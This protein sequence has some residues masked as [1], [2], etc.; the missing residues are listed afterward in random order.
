MLPDAA[1]IF[2]S[3]TQRIK[4]LAGLI[5]LS[6]VSMLALQAYFLQAD[7]KTKKADFKA[8]LDAML[9]ITAQEINMLRKEEINRMHRLD[10]LDTSYVKLEYD[11]EDPEGPS[12]NVFKVESQSHELTYRVGWDKVSKDSVSQQYLFDRFFNPIHRDS[13]S[14]LWAITTSLSD[15]LSAYQ[16]TLSADMDEFNHRLSERLLQRSINPN[17]EIMFI[18]ERTTHTFED[19][20]VIASKGVQLD[21]QADDRYVIVYFERP[22]FN[23]FKRLYLLLAA[24]AVVVALIIVS[25]RL[26]MKTISKQRKLSQLKDDFIDNVTHELLTPIATMKISLETLEQPDVQADRE[27]IAKY[28]GL[29]VRELNRV[30]GIVHNV[31][32]TSLHEQDELRLNYEEVDLDKLITGLIS[33]HTEGSE[34]EVEFRYQPGKP[35][36]VNTDMQHI[37]NVLHN[38]IDNA[39]KYNDQERPMVEI[40]VKQQENEVSLTIAD[41]GPGI[42]RG[43]EEKI[44]GK[45]HRVV[46][47]NS[48]SIGGLGVGL[49]Y[50]RNILSRLNGKIQ[51]KGNSATGSAFEVTLKS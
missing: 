30:S 9:E 20:R 46:N 51:L 8:D 39:I 43:H 35:I 17:Y 10:M 6:L 42:A 12:I 29:S 28:V 33:Y 23:V 13:K 37:S 50:V 36:L 45:F 5:G 14:M 21:H 34:K 4:L 26:L 19:E 11:L 27:K 47:E 40:R 2:T 44:F 22:F 32:Q 48:D 15:R 41:N 7:F 3:M 49:Y 38:L 16:D 31:L 25:F 24:S 1:S 18:K